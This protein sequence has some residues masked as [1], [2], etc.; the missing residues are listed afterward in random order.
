MP[1]AKKNRGQALSVQ[2]GLFRSSVVMLL[3]TIVLSVFLTVLLQRGILTEGKSG[4]GVMLLLLIVS[5]TGSG[6]SAAKIKHQ[7]M[8]MC[9]YSGLIYF[10]MLLGITAIFYGAQ[11]EAVWQTF[12]VIGAGTAAAAGTFGR[13][14]LSLVKKRR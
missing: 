12:A 4:Y 6:Y 14:K 9:L 10:L 1:T 11:Y 5:F 2:A 3:L 13:N 8:M 7:K